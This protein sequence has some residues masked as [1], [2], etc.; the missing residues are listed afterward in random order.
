M[1]RERACGLWPSLD[2]ATTAAFCHLTLPSQPVLQCQ[3]TRPA[4]TD[5]LYSEGMRA[6]LVL[7]IFV[8][9][10]LLGVATPARASVN[11]GLGADWMEGG[12]RDLN[13]TLG[14]DAYLARHLSLGGRAGAAFFDG[15]HH[16]GIPVDLRLR[17]HVQKIYFEGL[18]G[19]W[20]LVDSGDLFRFH[21][22]F[23]FGIEAGGIALGLEVG[24]LDGST[25][26][27][28]RV[29]FRL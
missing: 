17:L 23:G 20:L 26:V 15:G 1:V 3:E 25:M 13:L 10:A 24:K 18:V 21:G 7:S 27:G 5:V 4:A 28:L 8:F 6:H 11:L 16:I 29:A 12:A 14:A 19:P 2:V 22:A 9:A